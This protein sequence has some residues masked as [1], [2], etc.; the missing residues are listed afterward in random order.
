[1]GL[2]T[3]AQYDEYFG[4]YEIIDATVASRGMFYFMMRKNGGKS[5]SRMVRLTL[6]E[7]GPDLAKNNMTGYD[8]DEM[9]MDMAYPDNRIFVMDCDSLY[10]VSP[11]GSQ[12]RIP[13]IAQGGP[14]G[15]L[16]SRVRAIGRKTTLVLSSSGN[17]LTR[18]DDEVWTKATPDVDENRP[19]W[20]RFHDFDGYTPGDIYAGC[21]EGLYHFDGTSWEKAK[22][23]KGGISA[24]CCAPDGFV[25]ATTFQPGRI[26]LY[27]GRD[28]TWEK[29]FEDRNKESHANPLNDLVWHDGM[30]WAS[31]WSELWTW[32]D[33]E[34]VKRPSPGNGPTGGHLSVRD[35]VLLCGGVF[36]GFLRETGGDWQTLFEGKPVS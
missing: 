5:G 30:L 7:D 8:T 27:K 10:F 15:S 13:T 2:L 32:K 14:L 26:E 21:D 24:V 28:E 16:I 22:R 11:K 34:P 35:D 17:V 29:I 12:P 18:D 20:A 19:S 9:F 3:E 33:G 1:M 31:S 23:P 25:Y 6:S 36:G 4:G